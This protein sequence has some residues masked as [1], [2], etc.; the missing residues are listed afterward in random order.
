MTNKE[1]F[2]EFV[3]AFA[4]T[5]GILSVFVMFVALV[6]EPERKSEERFKVVDTYATCAIVQYNPLSRAESVYFLDC[7]NSHLSERE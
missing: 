4:L 7:Q 5:I 2:N 1:A 6:G 3:R